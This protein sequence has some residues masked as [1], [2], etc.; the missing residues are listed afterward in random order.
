MRVQASYHMR[1]FL[2]NFYYSCRKIMSF[3]RLCVSSPAWTWCQ[4]LCGHTWINKTNNF[5]KFQNNIFYSET[6]I[7]KVST[8]DG[9]CTYCVGMNTIYIIHNSI[10]CCIFKVCFF[11]FKWDCFAYVIMLLPKNNS[12]NN[13]NKK[14]Y[15]YNPWRKTNETKVKLLLTQ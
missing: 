15:R 7:A 14:H 2:T 13:N 1:G 10:I 6:L 5:I 11:L 4:I 12:R 8:R 3:S 9:G